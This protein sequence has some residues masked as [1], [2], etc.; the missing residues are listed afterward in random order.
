MVTAENKER[1]RKTVGI[2]ISRFDGDIA[3]CQ[4]RMDL[5]EESRW[6]P[7][8]LKR[9]S[10]EACDLM[11]GDYFEWVPNEEGMVRNEDITKHPRRYNPEDVEA[12]ERVFKQLREEWPEEESRY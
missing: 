6:L 12:S 5:K 8:H 3:Y 2:Q 11:E 10:L 4:A 9:N 1:P 7:V